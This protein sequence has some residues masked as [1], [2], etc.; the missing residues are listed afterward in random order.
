MF[1][2]T[3]VNIKEDIGPLKYDL[4]ELNFVNYYL[5]SEGIITIPE[6]IQ[7]M[8]NIHVIQTFYESSES[9]VHTDIKY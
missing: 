7:Q 4:V 6:L 2:K 8:K 1:Q 5:G 3:Q 9:C